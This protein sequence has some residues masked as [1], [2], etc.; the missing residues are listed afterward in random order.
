MCGA[1]ASLLHHADFGA[2]VLG[3][4]SFV[5][6]GIGGHLQ[7]EADCLDTLRIRAVRDQCFADRFSA[8]L[9][10][11]AIVFGCAAFVCEPGDDYLAGA[12][13]KKASQLLNLAILGG[14]DGLA[15]EVEI[16]WL[17]LPAFNIAAEKRGAL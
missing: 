7:T 3:P 9:A 17:K 5:V 12:L 10:E 6:T 11:G 15:I 8:A 13:L 2:T 16:D 14:A 1:T 4:G